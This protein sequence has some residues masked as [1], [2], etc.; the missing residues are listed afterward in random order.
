MKIVGLVLW[1]LCACVL[2]IPTSVI[3]VITKALH[4]LMELLK[5]PEKLLPLIV[6]IAVGIGFIKWNE[7]GSGDILL[8]IVFMVIALFAAMVVSKLIEYGTA[9]ILIPV[10]SLYLILDF[11]DKN[12]TSRLLKHS[13][14]K[15]NAYRKLSINH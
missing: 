13:N 11:T 9:I 15:I 6:L 12:I 1:N 5:L 10:M 4:A 8:L 2:Y 14:Q 7:N 3:K